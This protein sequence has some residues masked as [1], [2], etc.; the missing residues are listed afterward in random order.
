M[1]DVNDSETNETSEDNIDL[2]QIYQVFA[3]ESI[4]PDFSIKEKISLDFVIWEDAIS[5]RTLKTT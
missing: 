5:I 4:L 2:F 3:T 1:V